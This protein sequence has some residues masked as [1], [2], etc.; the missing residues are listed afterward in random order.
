[1]PRSPA[2][3]RRSSDPERKRTVQAASGGGAPLAV[4]PLP[5][6]GD[7][8]GARPGRRAPGPLSRR[9]LARRA[10]AATSREEIDNSEGGGSR[11][12]SAT[13]RVSGHPGLPLDDDDLLGA[14]V[15]ETFMVYPNIFHDPPRS[16]ELAMEFMAV[17]G[18]PTSSRPSGS[19]RGWPGQQLCFSAG[20]PSRLD[21]GSCS[22]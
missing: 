16:L 11:G 15:L 17:R 8:G 9:I 12:E 21:G 5:R 2:G 10:G 13:S 14:V 4:P 1:M 22:A 7:R 18:P 3:S 19:S 6:R 20:A